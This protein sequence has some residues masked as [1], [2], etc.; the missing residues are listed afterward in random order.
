MDSGRGTM[1]NTAM[2]VASTGSNFIKSKSTGMCIFP[3]KQSSFETA[4][5]SSVSDTAA[6]GDSIVARSSTASQLASKPTSHYHLPSPL[7]QPN[8]R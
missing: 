5:N 2:T 8:Q 1:A 3:D 7:N 4:T 6:S